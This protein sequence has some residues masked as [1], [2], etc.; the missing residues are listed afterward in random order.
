MLHLGRYVV[1]AYPKTFGLSATPGQVRDMVRH[2]RTVD[3]MNMDY[4]LIAL[5][6]IPYERTSKQILCSPCPSKDP[7][8][9]GALREVPYM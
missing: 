9:A 3:K 6:V 7:A 5:F 2:H 1:N 4:N 8:V